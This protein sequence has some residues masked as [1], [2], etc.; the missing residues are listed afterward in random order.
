MCYGRNATDNSILNYY[1]VT[2]Y[3]KEYFFPLVVIQGDFNE[4]DVILTNRKQ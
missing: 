3:L 1:K 2:E 4:E